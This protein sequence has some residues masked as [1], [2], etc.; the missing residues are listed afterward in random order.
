MRRTT[1][2]FGML[3]LAAMLAANAGSPLPS[4]EAC[5]MRAPQPVQV[6]LDRIEVEVHE[7]VVIKK[8]DC[9][10]SNPNGGVIV[11]GVCYMEL[12]PEAQVDNLSMKVG[13]ETVQAEILDVEKANQVFQDIV[14]NGGTPALLEYYGN[15][16]VRTQVPNVP[17]GGEVVVN[18]QYTQIVKPVSGVYRLSM[19]NTN[20]KMD[21]QALKRAEVSIKFVSEHGVS[22]VYS[23]THPITFDE[24]VEDGIQVRWSQENYLP[25]NPFVIYWS[26]DD[27]DIS[28]SVLAHRESGDE[29]GHFMAMVSPTMVIGADGS[30]DGSPVMPK[31]I[32]FVTDTSGS[33]AE[34]GK[35]EQAKDALKY[36]VENLHDGDRFNII[37][38]STTTRLFKDNMVTVDADSKAAALK[39][40]INMKAR[41]GTA[42]G[43][44]LDAA[45]AQFLA[46]DE[47]VKMILFSTDGLPTIGERD[48]DTLLA[49]V[50]KANTMGVRLFAF[51][52]G[53]NVNARL[54]DT[55]AMQN[56]GESDFILPEE[57][58]KTKIGNYFDRIGSP[59]LVDVRV[60]ITGENVRVMDLYPRVA[61]D[62][63]RGDR[64]V[65]FGRYS[66]SGPA[67]VTVRGLVN[68]VERKYEFDI[69]LPEVA[70]KNSFVPRLWAGRKVHYLLGEVRSDGK[71]QELIDEIVKLAM[72][73]G[74]VTPYTAYLAMTDGVSSME[75]QAKNAQNG[76]RRLRSQEQALGAGGAAAPADLDAMTRA[77]GRLAESRDESRPGSDMY[78]AAEAERKAMGGNGSVLNSMRYIGNRTFYNLQGVWTDSAYEEA[79]HQSLLK[80]LVVNS[81]EYFATLGANP[82]LARFLAVKNGIIH[83]GDAWYRLVPE[84]E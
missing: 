17:A 68:G 7:N 41:G 44:A 76:F 23:P 42:I 5:F 28:A 21:M 40:V 55:L 70:T 74:I 32:V 13:G 50:K 30:G 63:F 24:T 10:F 71:D 22:N 72:R 78:N 65:L 38:F 25:K 11:G 83:F 47:R 56:R 75:E 27:K 33:M 54:L 64:V 84:G 51:G 59:M 26:L 43:E 37:D 73:Y 35:I 15:R 62:L 31:D 16:L 14:R 6:V 79:K 53:I 67:H 57:N 3:A 12:D 2:A 8:Y 9:H 48:A 39:Y 52:E 69:E 61:A 20:P 4:A 58:I 29:E 77:A 45:L 82:G 1:L 18:L 34:N 49:N 60:D 46:G 80:K 81:D 19:L 36:C 66:G